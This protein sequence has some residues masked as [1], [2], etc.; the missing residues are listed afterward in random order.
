MRAVKRGGSPLPWNTVMTS[1]RLL[2]VSTLIFWPAMALAE[3]V[4]WQ[5]FA[6][7]ESG[8]IV[9]IPTSVFTEDAGKPEV[10][11]GRRFQSADHR[12]NLTVQSL[13]NDRQDSPVV[14]LAKKNPPTNVVY[15]K[16]TDR[17]F[18]VSSF[19]GD[20]IFYDRCNFAGPF[21]NCVLINYPAA[22]KRR[23]DNVVT[24]ISKTMASR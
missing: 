17:F 5:K 9:Q 7:P 22:E 3:P 20:K 15:K 24:R 13:R 4:G 6:V 23:W 10:G 21:I 1:K 16:I 11:Y 2:L 18:V 8:A 14:F 19:R 12:A